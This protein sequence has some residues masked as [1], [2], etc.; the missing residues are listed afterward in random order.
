MS[1]ATTTNITANKTIHTG[2]GAVI[3]LIIS[4]SEASAQTVTIYDSLVASGTQLAVFKVSP[5]SSPRQIVFPPPYF[6][7]FSTGLTISPGNCTVICQ[8]VGH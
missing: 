7:R 3:S 4:H 1:R 2:R 8:S 5:E 6:L